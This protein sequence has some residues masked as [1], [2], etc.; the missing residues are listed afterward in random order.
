[1][2]CDSIARRNDVREKIVISTLGPN[3]TCSEYASQ[4]F[5]DKNDYDGKINL[6]STFEQAVEDLKEGKS[7]H[8]IIPSAYRNFA[9]I[10]FQEQYTI[11]ID[12]VFKLPT[13]NLVIANKGNENEI[14][15][16]ATHSS[17]S[18]L[19]K[20][21]FPNAQLVISKSNSNAAEMLLA[22]KVDA[23]ITTIKCAEMYSLNIIHNF[24]SIN[25]GWNVLKRK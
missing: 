18:S 16:V 11:E 25:M 1:M 13:P 24:G 19:V 15:K 22:N 20:E 8:V 5:L 10:I 17:P 9:D 4:F 6:F 7:D 21:Y 3:G 14:K 23:C 12:D 2:S